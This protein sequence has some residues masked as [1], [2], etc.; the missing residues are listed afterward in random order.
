[1][2]YKAFLEKSRKS[3][4]EKFL[5]KTIEIYSEIVARHQNEFSKSNNI[6]EL[7]DYMNIH[8]VNYRN[9]T[10]RGAFKLYLMS[11]GVDE[12][13][14]RLR[15]L[16]SSKKNASALTS[17]RVLGEK[18]IQKKDLQILYD[19]VDDEWKLIIGFLYDTACRES[20]ML[21]T[22]WKDIT[23]Y[24]EPVGNIFGEAMVLGKGGKFRTVFISEPTIILLKKLRPKINE[25]D[26]VFTFRKIDGELHLHQ[27]KAL[28]DGL[29][30]RSKKYIGVAKSPHTLRH[31][32]LTHLSENGAD[33]LGISSIAGHSNISTT[34]IY[35]KMSKKVAKKTYQDYTESL[36]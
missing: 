34:N 17:V 23:F 4:G 33:I 20:E 28:I 6:E 29:K 22:K 1:M 7:I 26:L 16:K 13:D 35:A 9:P 14:E 5:P 30:K 25:N 27:E 31:S 24:N 21:S 11:L 15:L 10:M 8:I 12:E 18:V 32:K 19:S 2:E 36:G 3:N